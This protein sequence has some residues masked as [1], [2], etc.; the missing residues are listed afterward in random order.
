LGW[1]YKVLLQMRDALKKQ[2]WVA[3]RD[4]VEEHQVLMDLSHITDMRDDR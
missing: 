3:H 1:S 4:M 2:G